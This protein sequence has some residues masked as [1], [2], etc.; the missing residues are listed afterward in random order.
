MTRKQALQ[1]VLKN[2]RNKEVI[3]K[4]NEIIDDL[5]FRIWSESAAIDSVEQF[6]LENKRY[7]ETREFKEGILPSHTLIRKRFKMSV[8]E[9]LD[10][11]FPREEFV[12]A[13]SLT[14][15]SRNRWIADFKIQ[16]LAINPSNATAYDKTRRQGSPSWV[17][18]AKL[19][20]VRTW[21]QLLN[22]CEL[23]RPF[24]IQR[25]ATTY[26]VASCSDLEE[27]YNAACEHISKLKNKDTN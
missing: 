22:Y 9:F 15:K 5:P 18:V 27:Q 25:V 16:Y 2:T 14:E 24:E 12:R 3:K 20:K 10:T 19:C 26:N 23:L 1:A 11:H 21:Y 13:A 8:L 4:I 7:P 6:M 17:Q